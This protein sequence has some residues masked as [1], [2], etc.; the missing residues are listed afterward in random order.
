MTEEGHGQK[1]VVA[2]SD[3]TVLEL[4]QIRLDIAGYYACVARTGFAALDLIKHVR[5]AAMIVDA[6]LQ[7]MDGFEVIRL[8]RARHPDQHFPILLT[9]RGL[10]VEDVQRALSLGAQSCMIKPFSGADAL[11]RVQR[12]LRAP[13]KPAFGARPMAPVYI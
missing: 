7:E 3:R 2:D 8:V 10:K 12:L 13:V 1:I 11:E 9:G 4:L 5:P 6:A